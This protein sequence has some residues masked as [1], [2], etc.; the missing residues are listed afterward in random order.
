MRELNIYELM[1]GD[2]VLHDLEPYQI[3]QLGIYGENRDGEDYPAVCIGKPNGIGLII[4]RNKIEPMPI[5]SEILKKNEFYYEDNVGHVL[6]HYNYIIIYDTWEHELRI[7]K[8][9]E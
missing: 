9:C 4:E 2:W 8:N 3:R 5:T 1:I 6:E 7:L